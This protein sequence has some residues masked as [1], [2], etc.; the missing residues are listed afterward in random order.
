LKNILE[1]TSNKTVKP[2]F[3]S[4]GKYKTK[5]END[6]EVLNDQQ[7]ILGVNFDNPS[8]IITEDIT[9]SQPP[10]VV[11][12]YSFL[13]SFLFLNNDQNILLVEESFKRV[14]YRRVSKLEWTQ[15]RV[16][17]IYEIINRQLF[18][19]IGGLTFGVQS[20]NKIMV[21]NHAD[22]TA[23]SSSIQTAVKEI[24]AIKICPVSTSEVYL[25]ITGVD[26]TYSQN[27]TDIFS[28]KKV[29]NKHIAK[30]IFKNPESHYTEVKKQFPDLDLFYLSNEEPDPFLSELQKDIS[31]LT[32]LRHI[33]SDEIDSLKRQI[34]DLQKKHLLQDELIKKFEKQRSDLM[35]QSQYFELEIKKLISQKER[36]YVLLDIFEKE[37]K[38]RMK[39]SLLLQYQREL[40][41]NR[42]S[43]PS[44]VEDESDCSV[45]GNKESISENKELITA[46]Q[47]LKAT[48]DTFKNERREFIIENQRLKLT[49]LEIQ[50]KFD[51]V[52][53]EAQKTSDLVRYWY[54]YK[55][56]IF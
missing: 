19:R 46:M 14:E 5:I 52:V 24:Y 35:K 47:E 18:C 29:L 27:Q 23:S 40:S 1:G 8:Q 21:I 16:Y 54:T 41:I 44:L 31:K 36:M 55:F 45:D 6:F 53:E 50:A 39:K 4:N 10:V 12:N 49:Q 20:D 2:L 22:Q 11:G 28:I 42:F 43:P 34:E 25:A 7:I 51:K 30:K 38:I 48:L 32:S 26:K 37:K 3:Q 13:S 56:I 9:S 33:S 15:Q 17:R